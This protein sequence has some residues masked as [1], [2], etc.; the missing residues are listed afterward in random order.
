MSRFLSLL[1]GLVRHGGE[2]ES[3]PPRLVLRFALYSGVL[4]R[5]R[6]A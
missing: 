4:A 3:R 1:T 6:I 2:D 5:L